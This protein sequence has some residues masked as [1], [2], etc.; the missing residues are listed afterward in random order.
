MNI[1]FNFKNFEPSEHLRD[2]AR[3]RFD[4]LTKYMTNADSSELL[5]NLSVE[6]TRQ[7]ADVIFGA[8]NIHIS[9]HEE[10]ED[11]Y[12]TIDLVLDKLES[13]VRKMREKMKDRRK[14]KA[15]ASME[16]FS[17]AEKT[18]G[19][20]T[21]QYFPDGQLGGERELVE[22]VKAGTIDLT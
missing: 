8:D 19:E 2:Y 17:F 9:A 16:I 20:V 15:Q 18:G 10:S 5:V 7:M 1:S 6:K 14:A 12:S 3:K 22:L 11:M 21:V 4:K 13:Q